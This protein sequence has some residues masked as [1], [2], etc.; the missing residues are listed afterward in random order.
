VYTHEYT[1]VL[2]RN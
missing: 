2:T 1:T